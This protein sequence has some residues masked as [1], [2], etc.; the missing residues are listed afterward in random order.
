[1][2]AYADFSYGSNGK[3]QGCFCFPVESSI[4]T[5]MVKDRPSTLLRLKEYYDLTDWGLQESKTDGISDFPLQYPDTVED[6]YKYNSVYSQVNQYPTFNPKPLFFEEQTKNDTMIVASEKKIN[7]ELVDNWTK[8]LYSNLME[9]PTN[10]GKITNLKTVDTKLMCWQEKGVSVIAVNDRYVLS[11]QPGQLA[12]GSGGI[13]ERYDYL[14]TECGATGKYVIDRFENAV[15]WIDSDR[16][17]LFMFDSSIKELISSKGVRN[18]IKNVGNFVNPTI[19]VDMKTNK[20]YFK[21]KDEVLVYD[22][23]LQLFEGIHTYDPKWFVRIFDNRLLSSK[24]D[25]GMYTSNEGNKGEFYDTVY[26]SYIKTVCTDN[27]SIT[28]VFDTLEWYSKTIRNY[29]GAK[30]NIFDDTFS[31]IRVTNDTQ[32]TG[33][34]PLNYRRSERTFRA[35]IPRDIVNHDEATDGDIFNNANLDA[36]QLFKRRILDRYANIELEY[37]NDHDYSFTVPYINVNYR[38]SNR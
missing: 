20:I 11:E 31:T 16:N 32:N 10:Q 24:G 25:M 13:L 21:L 15:F 29:L 5:I 4:N 18:Y 27:F 23:F 6:L 2:F 7:G 36:T 34:Q 38:V 12:L 17:K 33:I 3:A 30:L 19:G 9:L 37:N 22:L 14:S 28:K 26:P 8:F 1:M 35:E